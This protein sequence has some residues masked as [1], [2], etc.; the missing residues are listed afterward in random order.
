MELQQN[1]ND[2][3]E[4]LNSA[5]FSLQADLMKVMNGINQLNLIISKIKNYQVN[6]MNNM[7]MG[8]NNMNDIQ[9]MNMPIFINQLNGMMN[10]NM[11]NF[12]I[13]NEHFEKWNLFF[14]DKVDGTTINVKISPQNFVKEAIDRYLQISGKTGKIIFLFNSKELDP[15]M[16]INKSGLMNYS[17]ISVRV[18]KN[19]I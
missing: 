5:V 10:N 12:Q 1:F 7:N 3:I 13:K 4:E 6:N 19:L 11:M 2:I 18:L 16:K 9:G 17:T 14:E 8:M 15:N